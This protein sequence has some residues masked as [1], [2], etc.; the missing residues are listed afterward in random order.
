MKLVLPPKR[1]QEV[2]NPIYDPIRPKVWFKGLLKR[3]AKLPALKQAAL[4]IRKYGDQK[5]VASEYGVDEREL[6]DYI[7]FFSHPWPKPDPTYQHIM[8]KAYGMYCDF[9]ATNHI[10]FYLAIV[11]PFYRIKPR[12]V[13]ELWETHPNYY[14]TGYTL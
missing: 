8:D 3:R 10:R 2:N 6:R 12:H 7:A 4:G 14:P 9:N 5:V 11:A 13:E 1:F